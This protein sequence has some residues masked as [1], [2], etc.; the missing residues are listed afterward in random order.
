MRIEN[1]S[2]VKLNCFEQGAAQPLGDGAF[3]LV[4]EVS[5]IDYGAAIKRLDHAHDP[6]PGA[7]GVAVFRS[8][9]V[10]VFSALPGVGS[11]DGN[12]GKGGEVAAL[13][14]TTGDAKAVAGC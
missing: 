5:G 10:Y 11:I 13:F 3:D 7:I 2:I 6:N 9:P 1:L 8:F 12:L 4:P 14:K